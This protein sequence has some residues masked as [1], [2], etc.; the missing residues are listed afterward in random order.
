MGLVIVFGNASFPANPSPS[1]EQYDALPDPFGWVL[2]LLGVFALARANDSFDSSRW[3]A[4]IAAMASVP[5]WFPQLHH[6]L[7]A[8]GEWFASLPQLVFCLFLAR[9]IGLAGASRKP[10]DGYVAKRFGLLVWAFALAGVLPV[11]ALGG[12]V[13]QLEWPTLAVSSAASVAL[14]YLLFR[15]HRREWLG[16][17]GP[18]EVRPRKQ[19]EKREGRPPSR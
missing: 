5:M 18:L 3:L 19:P 17:P 12:N 16:G 10:P 4:V 15:V 1:W 6:R 8:S 7:D 9:E 13:T 11:L 14:V 2:V